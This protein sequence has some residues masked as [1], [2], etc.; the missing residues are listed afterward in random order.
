MWPLTSRDKSQKIQLLLPR[1]ITNLKKREQKGLLEPQIP[2][3][4][5]RA[6]VLSLVLNIL[7]DCMLLITRTM[8]LCTLGVVRFK[9]IL[10]KA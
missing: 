3:D 10:D 5:Y 8:L 4:I 2:N 7:L 9:I 1:A 6:I